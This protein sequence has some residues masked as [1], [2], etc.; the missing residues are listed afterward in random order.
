MNSN[1]EKHLIKQLKGSSHGAF[2]EIYDHYSKRVYAF[3][4]KSLKDNSEAENA[5]QTI[6][7]RLWEHREEL[8]E[9]LS[10]IAYL[11]KLTKNHI[12]NVNKRKI[13]KEILTE[14]L[15]ENSESQVDLNKD[16]DCKDIVRFVERLLEELPERRKEM[17]LLNRNDGLTYRE[18]ANKLNVSEN[19]VDTQIRNAL[20]YLREKVRGEFGG[21][22]II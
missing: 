10:L 22:G 17:F 6:F 3:S 20:N 11:F 8:N 15:K 12:I 16:I 18:I 13:Y 7:M 5:V 2:A 14:Y 1:R 4:V 21:F 9:E 19:T